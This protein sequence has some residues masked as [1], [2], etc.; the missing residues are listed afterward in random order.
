VIKILHNGS[1]FGG[2]P[3]ATIDELIEVMHR[4]R[5]ERFSRMSSVNP[6]ECKTYEVP[7]ESMRFFGNFENVSHAFDVFTDEPAT[8]ERL[9]NAF[10]SSYRGFYEMKP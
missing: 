5:L 1:K 10:Q 3:P 7:R 2:E 4:E 8:I 6:N 9:V